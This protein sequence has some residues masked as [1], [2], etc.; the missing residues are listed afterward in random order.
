MLDILVEPN[1]RSISLLDFKSYA[2]ISEIGYKEAQLVFTRHGLCSD[3]CE[4]ED[5]KIS[6]EDAQLVQA[7]QTST[8]LPGH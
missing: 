1:V 8:P 6:T 2:H 4:S 3:S 7:V 5:F